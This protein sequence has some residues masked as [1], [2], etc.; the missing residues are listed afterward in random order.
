MQLLCGEQNLDANSKRA[1][2]V[3]T[4][5]NVWGVQ[6]AHRGDCVQIKYADNLKMTRD[7][8]LNLAAWVLYV[9]GCGLEEFKNEYLDVIEKQEG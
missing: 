9:T 4:T 7:F 6:T 8:A 5:S 1:D 3:A 2:L